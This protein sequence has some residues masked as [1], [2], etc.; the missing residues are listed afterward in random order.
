MWSLASV[1]EAAKLALTI[2][3]L[4]AGSLDPTAYILDGCSVFLEHV[5]GQQVPGA[6]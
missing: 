1:L 2:T 5:Y 4:G 3:V 6:T